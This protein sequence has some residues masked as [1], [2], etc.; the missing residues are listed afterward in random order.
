M[1]L[2]LCSAGWL[3]VSIYFLSFG[4]SWAGNVYAKEFLTLDEVAAGS[5]LLKVEA[6]SEKHL[7]A[8]LL[9]SKYEIDISGVIARTTL[10]QR[11]INPS[12]YW[13]EGIYA[14]PIQH[15]A[16]IDGLRLRIGDRFIEGVVKEKKQA[17]EAFDTAKKEGKKA[18]L[19]VQH[20]PNLFTNSVVNIG[21][22]EYV[23]VQITYQ[24][25]IK[26]DQGRYTLR[27]PLV[28]APRYEAEPTLKKND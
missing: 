19:L 18:A 23:I 21:P 13:L 9:S 26:Q 10:T 28:A 3:F 27:L 16:A 22:G 4:Q 11:F 14:F 6:R 8:P 7:R 24:H 20:R 1:K 5:L 12:D 15:S 17:Q 25:I 2:R